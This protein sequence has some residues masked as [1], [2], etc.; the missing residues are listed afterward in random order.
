M[1]GFQNIFRQRTVENTA[2]ALPLALA[3]SEDVLLLLDDRNK[4]GFGLA[5]ASQDDLFAPGSAFHQLRQSRFRRCDIDRL[6]L[7]HDLTLSAV[8]MLVKVWFAQRCRMRTLPG[9]IGAIL[10]LCVCAGW[11]LIE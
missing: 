2:D 10:Q 9:A 6:F 11:R 1:E 8:T 7:A 5:V 4:P 3:R